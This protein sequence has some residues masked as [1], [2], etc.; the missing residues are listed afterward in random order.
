MN[1]SQEKN[2]HYPAIIGLEIGEDVVT[3]KLS[4]GRTISIPV[5]WFQR[6][7]QANKKQ[8]LNYEISPSGYGVHWPELD[9]DIS[10][11]AFVE[12]YAA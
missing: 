8:L 4:D 3:A 2:K 12:G 10:I 7:E 5:A 1:L 6:L 9:E 11:K